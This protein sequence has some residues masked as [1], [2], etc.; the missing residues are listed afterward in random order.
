M[1]TPNY[2]PLDE[3]TLKIIRMNLADDAKY[4]S[5]EA[6]PYHKDTVKMLVPP[7]P[8]EKTAVVN[9][10]DRQMEIL[11]KMRQQLD[12]QGRRLDADELAD[13]AANAYFRQRLS[14]EKEI[15]ELEKELHNIE[16]V[17]AF[18]ATVLTIME[19]VLETDQRDEVMTKLRA[20]KERN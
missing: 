16:N 18:F 20:I 8:T 17:D 4:L 1:T 7:I 14:V 11:L 12:E 2:P 10:V 6:C 13:S 15:I 3:G 5:N 19:D 9:D